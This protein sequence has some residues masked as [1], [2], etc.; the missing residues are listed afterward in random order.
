[1]IERA[2]FLLALAENED[3]TDTRLVYADWLDGHGEYDEATRQR[4]WADAKA[5]MVAFA[6][7]CVAHDWQ[8]E[9]DTALTFREVMD[10]ASK[11]TDYHT[12][13]RHFDEKSGWYPDH[14]P[15]NLYELSDN[16]E[17]RTAFWDAWS[18]LTGKKP[19]TG[20][21]MNP[22]VCCY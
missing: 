6:T 11:Y 14:E 7:K 22:F 2:A 13:E 12:F 21:A 17:L 4:K 9:T 16:E 18:T 5:W 10:I 19:P 15:G 20:T 8:T 3:D 1:M